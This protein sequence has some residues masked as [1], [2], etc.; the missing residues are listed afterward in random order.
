MKVLSSEYRAYVARRPRLFKSDPRRH[1][2]EAGLVSY[3]M[4]SGVG[5]KLQ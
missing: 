1:V 2:M 5:A 3:P 4:K